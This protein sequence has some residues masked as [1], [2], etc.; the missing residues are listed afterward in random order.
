MSCIYHILYTALRT[1]LYCTVHYSCCK[2]KAVGVAQSLWLARVIISS[3]S[4]LFLLR[5]IRSEHH[6]LPHL[7]SLFRF[8]LSYYGHPVMSGPVT[9][10]RY[11]PGALHYKVGR[12]KKIGC[13]C[14]MQSCNTSCS[15][16]SFFFFSFLHSRYQHLSAASVLLITARYNA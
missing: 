11:L 10:F 13:F 9:L 12:I 8:R 3:Q 2:Q 5:V 6:L 14:C 15:Y 1:V 7:S 16:V 4:S